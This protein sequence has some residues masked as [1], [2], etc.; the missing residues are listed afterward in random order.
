M[1]KSCQEYFDVLLPYALMYG[2][3]LEE[4][5]YG[6]ADLFFAYRTSFMYKRELEQNDIDT[7]AWL[8]GLYVRQALAELWTHGMQSGGT[9]VN[10]HKEP[11]SVSNR[12]QEKID[13]LQKKK[14]ENERGIKFMIAQAHLSLMR[15]K[16]Q[17]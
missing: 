10:Y 7:H 17:K 2:M 5:W 6:E 8:S 15:Q 14:D 11:I 16:G 9:K 13:E 3:S 4:F 1:F 12:K